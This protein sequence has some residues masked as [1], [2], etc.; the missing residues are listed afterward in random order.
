MIFLSLNL[1]AISYMRVEL[2]VMVNEVFS[3]NYSLVSSIHIGWPISVDLGPRLCLINKDTDYIF[4]IGIF[5][6]RFTWL[7]LKPHRDNWEEE[8]RVF[9]LFFYPVGWG[10]RTLI[11]TEG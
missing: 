3:I 7:N 9:S 10:Y 2:D 1:Q 8:V 4:V 11:S 6:I 5:V